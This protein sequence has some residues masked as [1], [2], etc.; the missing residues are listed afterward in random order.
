MRTAIVTGANV[1]LG[2][3]T[4]LDLSG[5]GY[6]VILACRNYE[7]AAVAKARI[8]KQ[9]P[10]AAVEVMVI[11]TSSLASVADF[12]TAYTQRYATLDLLIN[13]AGIMM[14]PYRI[15]V[16]GFESQ[17]A[18]NYIG[19]FALTGRLLPLLLQTP[20]SR[21]V[22]LSSLAHRWSPI[23]LHDLHFEGGY[24]KRQAYG[25]SKLACLMFAYELDRRLRE[26]GLRTVSVAAHPGLS[27]T[28][29]AQHMPPMFQWLSPLIGQS[30]EAG[31]QPTLYAALSP[32]IRGGEYIGPDGF[33]EWRG[34]PAQVSSKDSSFD[35][36]MAS[37]LWEK[38]EEMTGVPYNFLVH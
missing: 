36:R 23:R 11:D 28:S 25:Q 9:I 24:S 33:Q 34:N 38:S 37:A 32:E 20:G 21:V 26:H 7:K 19:H 4:A 22:S 18:T 3:E 5:L 15:T 1:G 30:A 14:V 27:N 31:A 12:A 10:W 6:T 13:N 2:Y 16:D 17:L 8:L 29:L 35:E